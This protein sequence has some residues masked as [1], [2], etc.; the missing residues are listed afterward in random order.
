MGGD[1]MDVFKELMIREPGLLSRPIEELAPIS[2][3]GAAAVAAYRSIV[4][5][6]ADLP[7]TEEQKA[8]TLKDAQEAGEMLLAIEARIGELLPTPGDARKLSG[9]ASAE[10]RMG[11]EP[12]VIPRPPTVSQKQAYTARVIKDNPDVVAEVIEE[13]KDNE[14]LPTKT[15]VVN[16]VRFKAEQKRRKETE[17]KPTPR[18]VLTLKQTEYINT[19]EGII[20]DLPKAPPKDWSEDAFAR[21]SGLARIIINR[22]E[23]FNG[24]SR[25]SISE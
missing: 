11:K 5:K 13:A 9:K 20:E 19:L 10:K 17:G 18:L 14:D 6:L 7:I 8:K 23:A 24:T 16:K 22:L 15:A 12:T 4:A 25:D 21:A 2:F 1:A 3:V